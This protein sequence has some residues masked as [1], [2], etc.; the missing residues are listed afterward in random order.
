MTYIKSPNTPTLIQHSDQDQRVPPPQAFELYPG[1]H[2]QNVPVEA[3]VVQR[4][5]AP[6]QR[7]QSQ[8]RRDAAEFDWFNKYLWTNT[9]VTQ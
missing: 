9:G 1:L 7:T 3:R 6:A 2:D 5:R 8:S 4:L